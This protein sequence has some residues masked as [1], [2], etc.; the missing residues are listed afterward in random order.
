MEW[1]RPATNA[2]TKSMHASVL[3]P[4]RSMLIMTDESRYGWAHGITPR[5]IDVVQ[6]E[7]G[8]LTT[9][10]RNTRIS[11]TFRWRVLWFNQSMHSTNLKLITLQLLHLG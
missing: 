8:H 7:S 6:N 2:Q 4:R 1:N 10:K 9:M 5:K 3:V 11:F